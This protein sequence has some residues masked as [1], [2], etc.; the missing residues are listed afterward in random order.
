MAVRMQFTGDILCQIPQTRACATAHGPDYRPVFAP[1]KT[2]LRDCD[3]LVGNLETPIAGETLGY[4]D[5]LYQFNTPVAFL[6]ALK[7]AGFQLL[8]TANNH[9]MDRGLPGLLATLDHLDAAGLEHTGTF[10]SREER[11]TPLVRELGGIRFGFLSYTYGT[12]AFFHHQYLPGNVPWAVNLLQPEE[13]REGAIDLLDREGVPQKVQALYQ[14]E[15]PVFQ[16]CIAPYLEALKEDIHRLRKAG[17]EY[18][19][20]L[21]H[22]GGQHDLMPD[23][24]TQWIVRWL[25]EA[26]V[27]LIVGHHQHI[28]H[29]FAKLSHARVA[30]CLGNL[31]DTPDHNPNGR[32]IG[33]EYSILLRCAFERRQGRVAMTGC[34]FIPVKSVFDSRGRAVVKEVAALIGE[35]DSPAQKA[36]IM[37]DLAHFVNLIQGK[38][39]NTPVMPAPDYPLP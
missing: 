16:R 18:L 26:G 38:P 37:K 4:S 31:T 36:Q 27:D 10:R 25:D 14:Q 8:S 39:E 20:M 2:L 32:G 29:P 7:D 13:E 6:D 30:Y 21:L 33:E 12:N 1:I 19:I 5:R 3:Y 9:C 17:A 28:L 23:A 34:T 22:C 15:N 24:Y 35:A 11:E